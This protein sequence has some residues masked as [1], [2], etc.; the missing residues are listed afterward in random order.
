M[1]ESTLSLKYT[2][3]ILAV[4]EYLGYGR[5][6]TK[7]TVAQ[8]AQVDSIVQSGYRQFLSPPLLP[9]ERQVHKWHFLKPIE[10]V[11]TTATKGEVALPDDFGGIEGELTYAAD[12]GWIAVKLTS[13]IR[14]RKYRQI[15][16]D[17][18]G[19]PVYAAVV[20]KESDQ[21]TGQRFEL[22]LWPIPDA[23]YTLSYRK[24][25]L[26]ETLAAE[27]PYPLGG[28]YHSETVLQSCLAVAERRV[29]DAKGTQWDHFMERL[30]ASVAFD[31]EGRADSLGQ[32]LDPSSGG[33]VAW[34]RTKGYVQ[35]NG[36]AYD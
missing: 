14:I 20:P 27:T 2:D 25:P 36:V 26:M 29:N 19:K 15:M 4:G 11:A 35:Y 12:E 1:A 34:G 7:W 23:A 30:G 32:N 9:G 5:D 16:A 13:D 28:A 24:I 8:T 3:F 31:R 6:A 21:K 17:P 18:A 10:T 22:W 33:G